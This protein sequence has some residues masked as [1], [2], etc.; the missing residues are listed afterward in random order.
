ML[1]AKSTIRY[2]NWQKGKALCFDN[3][4]HVKIIVKIVITK[5][6]PAS[7]ADKDDSHD[8]YSNKNTNHSTKGNKN[9]LSLSHV[10]TLFDQQ[11]C[12]CW[13]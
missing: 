8:D 6:L 13:F 1:T 4:H 9:N 7:N 5:H 11:I 3:Y 12:L 2:E 10:Q